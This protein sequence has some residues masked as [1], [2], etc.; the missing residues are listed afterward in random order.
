MQLQR[1]DPAHA[2]EV[3]LGQRPG[4]GVGCDLGS[5]AQPELGTPEGA[6]FEGRASGQHRRLVARALV[7]P[8][9]M[10]PQRGP[11]RGAVLAFARE[12]RRQQHPGLG[13]VR[14]VG[15]E[16]LGDGARLRHTAFAQQDPTQTDR[17]AA[18]ELQRLGRDGLAGGGAQRQR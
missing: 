10:G 15:Q 13:I 12:C 9:Q 1:V 4:R 7:A 5:P 6:L 14:V 3:L 2:V 17:L 18:A 11:V 8:A 16:R